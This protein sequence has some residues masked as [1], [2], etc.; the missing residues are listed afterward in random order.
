MVSFALLNPIRARAVCA[1]LGPV[2]PAVAAAL[3]VPAVVA[4]AL[5]EW[6]LAGRLAGAATALAGLGAWW[7]RWTIDA[8]GVTESLAIVALAYLAAAV[9]GSLALWPDVPWVEA[10]FESMSGFT[11][12]GLSA[13]DESA[14][15]PAQHVFR[16]WSQ[17]VGGLGIMV[18]SLA[19]LMRDPAALM[20]ASEVSQ[21]EVKDSLLASVRTACTVYAVLS[22]A[23]GT[24]YAAVGV[25]PAA[26]A[27]LTMTTVSTGGFTS[28][29]AF[30]TGAGDAVRAVAMIG[31]VAGAIAFT[32]FRRLRYLRADLQIRFG[33][34]LLLAVV[35]LFW[36]MA[37]T[38]S[39]GDAFNAVSA[40]TDTGFTVGAEAGWPAGQQA[41]AIVALTIGGSAGST[42]GGLKLVRFAIILAV[43][44]RWLMR[45][46][47][48]PS[49]RL[50]LRIGG[51]PVPEEEGSRV[52]AFA[53]AYLLVLIAGALVLALAG[54]ELGP[55]LFGSASALGTTGMWI[56]EPI[57]SLPWWAVLA[58]SIEMWAGRL[59]VLAVLVLVF[60]PL[61]TRWRMR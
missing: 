17:W 61:W 12:T 44:G 39:L 24:G 59:E 35:L 9:A 25:D 18:V 57:G 8:P 3:A 6:F 21:R 51:R 46:M 22:L 34:P 56:G 55:S 41:V 53:S 42:A 10:L 37:G 32:S 52:L 2:L 26:A 4:G 33:A 16:S 36:A 5:G 43:A 7:R 48:P 47:L 28:D 54:L 14:L 13:V 27:L 20:Y 40:A 38:I 30:F 15:S 58:L 60:P 19:V 31:M 1:H 50:P 45:P 49:A 29:P 11:T 23:V